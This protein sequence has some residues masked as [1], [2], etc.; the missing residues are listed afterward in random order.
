MRDSPVA[1]PSIS[2]VIRARTARRIGAERMLAGRELPGEDAEG[3]D[4][5]A[6]VDLAAA[7]LLGRHVARRAERGPASVSRVIDG[8]S[9][10][11]PHRAR[12]KSSTLIWPSLAPDD[13]LRLQIAMDD[14]RVVRGGERGGDVDERGQQLREAAADR[15]ASSSRS[16]R[17]RTSSR[18]DVQLAVDFLER[19][20]GGDR[21]DARARRPRAPRA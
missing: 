18:D 5:G 12:P 4:V 11:A 16:V 3:E 13:V 2:S 1:R 7:Q 17:P 8:A 19:E 15:R 9:C 14:A 20:D 10:R 21:R 6:R